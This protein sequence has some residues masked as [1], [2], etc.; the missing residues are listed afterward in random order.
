[1]QLAVLLGYATDLT[2]VGIGGYI[3]PFPGIYLSNAYYTVN[4]I[5]TIKDMV[6]GICG[7]F[8]KRIKAIKT[9]LRQKRTVGRQ[10]DKDSV[11]GDGRREGES[12][13]TV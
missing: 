5:I 4:D 6:N 7:Y 13:K 3:S 11:G 9:G 12:V 2:R 8:A 1:M 10:A